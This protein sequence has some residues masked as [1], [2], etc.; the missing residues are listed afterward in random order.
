[1]AK[2]GGNRWLIGVIVILV[3]ALVGAVCVGA[4]ALVLVSQ[5]RETT[6]PAAVN[7]TPGPGRSSAPTRVPSGSSAA[8]G[9]GNIL[10]LPGGQGGSVD[11]PTLDS[12]LSGD[13]A[14]AVYIVEIFSGLV[15][16]DPNLKV[17][18][19]LAEK[20]DLSDD[21]MTYT[22]KV[23][24]PSQPLQVRLDIEAQEN[25]L[26]EGRVGLM[27]GQELSFTQFIYP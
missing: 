25:G 23:M 13:A 18:P 2:S 4:G 26:L 10:R 22:F 11:P 1:M 7:N 19:D 21:R 17:V 3:L 27:D 20:W 12:A 8:P 16:L 15:S 5:S 24:E 14:S 6:G 9:G